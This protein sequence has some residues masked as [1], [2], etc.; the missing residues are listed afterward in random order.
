MSTYALLDSISLIIYVKLTANITATINSE[1]GTLSMSQWQPVT[2][3]MRSTSS[4][5]SSETLGKV[6]RQKMLFQFYFIHLELWKS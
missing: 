5:N 6:E 2:V 3:S 4:L 1:N